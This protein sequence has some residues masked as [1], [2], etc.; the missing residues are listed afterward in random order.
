VNQFFGLMTKLFFG[1]PQAPSRPLG[2]VAWFDN[3]YA[4]ATPKGEL[5]FGK[6][7][8]ESQWLEMDSVKIEQL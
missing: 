4:I 3:E 8:S 6:V 2:F 7:V 5:R 1:V